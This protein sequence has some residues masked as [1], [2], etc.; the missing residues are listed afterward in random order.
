M[1]RDNLQESGKLLGICIP[2]RG[3]IYSK[4]IEAVLVGIE[5]LEQRGIKSKVFITNDLPIP[6]AHNSCLERALEAG[7]E[8]IIFIEEDN[9]VGLE[10]FIQLATYD[11]D[12]A[13]L[14]YNDK[15]GSPHGIIHYNE[16]SEILWC[17]L[18]ATSIRRSVF[19]KLERPYFRTTTRYK[20][21][22]KRLTEDRRLITEYEK[23]DPH[24]IWDPEKLKMV[25]KEEPYI[26]GGLDVDFFTRARHAGFKIEKIPD[27]KSIHLKVSQMGEP[28]TNQGVH[29]ITSV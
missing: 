20:I 26:Y 29:Q 19:E 14:Q 5:A 8:R 7:C 10:E 9:Y 17:G 18:G 24:K 25:D 11:A 15:N 4:V 21:I 2:S 23:I 12:I 6:D 22:K 3:L 27:M 16:A 1:K 28:Y 13:T